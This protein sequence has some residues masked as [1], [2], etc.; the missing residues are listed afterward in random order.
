M[1][2]VL[3]GDWRGR[4][5]HAFPP[6]IFGFIWHSKGWCVRSL[7]SMLSSLF[8]LFYSTLCR[9]ASTDL[10]MFPYRGRKSGDTAGANKGSL[11]ALERWWRD[12]FLLSKLLVSSSSSLQLRRN[13]SGNR[14][15]LTWKLLIFLFLVLYL[16]TSVKSYQC[17]LC[18]R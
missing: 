8:I 5:R 14:S 16:V 4:G 17:K 1:L 18:P 2:V 11:W 12:C 13:C 3:W 15:F 7:M 10:E 9:C 6:A